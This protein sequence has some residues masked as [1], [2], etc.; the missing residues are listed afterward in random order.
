MPFLR[1][2]CVCYNC[3]MD[4]WVETGEAERAWLG[5]RDRR[6]GEAIARIGPLRRP[7][8]PNLF[9][10]LTH[11]IVGQQISSKAHAAIWGRV[12]A[13]GPVT[14]ERLAATPEETLRGVGLS[15]RKV[16]YIKRAAERIVDGRFDIE[17]LAAL[18]DAE[19]VARL[20][21]LDGIGTWSAEMLLL[22]SLRRPDVLSYG[23]FGIRRGICLLYRHR[24]LPRE[25]F[26]RYR[27][28]YSPY[29]STASLY[30]WA[31]AGG[32]GLATKKE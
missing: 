7:A 26:E 13:L 16:G 2:A 15:S 20:T 6:L 29:G 18:P 14:P 10:A 28:R 25:R 1:W 9:A 23:D 11:A 19:V 21:T 24:D 5:R 12:R 31:I 17:G 3:G 4:E 8:I 32:G 22:F 30:L 27:R